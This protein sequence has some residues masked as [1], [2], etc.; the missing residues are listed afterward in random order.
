MMAVRADYFGRRSFATIEGFASI[1]TTLGLVTGPLLV[2]FIA[3]SVG[4][5]RPGFLALACV[6]VAGGVSFAV[7]RRPRT[8]TP[9]TAGP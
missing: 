1:V 5:Y 8:L 2:G 4:D 7:A 3:D 6:T 9:G